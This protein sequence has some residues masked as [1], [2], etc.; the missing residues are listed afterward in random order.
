MAF[1]LDNYFRLRICVCKYLMFWIELFQIVNLRQTWIPNSVWDPNCVKNSV[2]S[3]YAGR[4]QKRNGVSEAI[5]VNIPLDFFKIIIYTK[6]I[7]HTLKV[8]ISL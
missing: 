1:S 2:F 7:S 3:F 6:F 4:I 5:D 8:H